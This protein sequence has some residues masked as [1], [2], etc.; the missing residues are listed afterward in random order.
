MSDISKAELTKYVGSGLW[1]KDLDV[2][3]TRKKLIA[4]SKYKHNAKR[5][6]FL[7]RL[8][9]KFA[10]YPDDPRMTAKEVAWLDDIYKSLGKPHRVGSYYRRERTS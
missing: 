2:E 6:D 9:R 4:C 5:T 3:G 8:L 7:N 10:E 1:L